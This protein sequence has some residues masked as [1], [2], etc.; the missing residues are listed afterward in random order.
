MVNH[1]NLNTKP[2]REDVLIQLKAL[3]ST[4]TDLADRLEQE[5]VAPLRRGEIPDPSVCNDVAARVAEFFVCKELLTQSS[6]DLLGC[7]TLAAVI[8]K[9]EAT[10]A[11]DGLASVRVA[12]E[13]TLSEV[14]RIA[15][16]P[17][18][19]IPPYVADL[20]T[21]ARD[22]KPV[23]ALLETSTSAKDLL[24]RLKPFQALASL[25]RDLDSTSLDAAEESTQ[26]IESA[27]GRRVAVAL[28][29]GR[30]HL[31]EDIPVDLSPSEII[32]IDPPIEIQ[33]RPEPEQQEAAAPPLALP[34]P[35]PDSIAQSVKDS[36]APR[37]NDSAETTA[38]LRPAHTDLPETPKLQPPHL[39]TEELVDVDPTIGSNE[40]RL[41]AWTLVSDDRCG[42]AYQLALVGHALKE[43]PWS[44]PAPLFKA[45]ALAPYVRPAFTDG[46]F[47][48]ET[49][50][51][52][53][54]PVAITTGKSL[55]HVDA[56]THRLALL[57]ATLRPAL[58][59][60]RCNAAAVVR[61][62]SP[63]DV[64]LKAVGAIRS[65]VQTFSETGLQ[66]D[67]TVL[68]GV[69]EHADWESGL[70]EHIRQL[71]QWLSQERHATLQYAPA[72]EVWRRWIDERG[73]IGSLVLELTRTGATAQATRNRLDTAI[74]EWSN[75]RD[76]GKWMAQKDRELRGQTAGRKPIEGPARLNFMSRVECFVSQ[77]RTWLTHLDSEPGQL[78]RHSQTKADEVRTAIQ[79]A[80]PAARTELRTLASENASDLFLSSAANLFDRALVQIQHLFDQ[81]V[82]ETITPR[83]IA[84]ALHVELLSDPNIPIE[85]DLGLRMPNRSSS[86]YDATLNTLRDRLL[87]IAAVPF[88]ISRA[89]ETA[90]QARRH[91][92]TQL[93]IDSLTSDNRDSD[94]YAKQREDHLALCR[95]QLRSLVT[96][97]KD[98]IE[99]AVCD[100]LLSAD[101]RS[102]LHGIADIDIDRVNDFPAVELDLKEVHESL[103][104]K[105]DDRAVSVARD[106]DL[107][108]SEKGDSLPDASRQII[109]LA[110]NSLEF[111]TAGEYVALARKGEALTP[112]HSSHLET[113][114][115]FTGTATNNWEDG[116]ASRFAKATDSVQPR[117]I[118][119]AVRDGVA[120]GPIQ[121]LTGSAE[122]RAQTAQRL[123]QWLLLKDSR[124]TRE[125]TT[126]SLQS[127]LEGLGFRE[128]AITSFT[129]H[130]TDNRWEAVIT[131]TPL[132][133]RNT[134]VVP[135]F[136]SEANGHYR[137]IGLFDRPNAAGVIRA[138]EHSR[139]D[140]ATLV[141]Y[142]GRMTDRLRRECA[143]E[144]WKHKCKFVVADDATLFFSMTQGGEPLSTLFDC[145]LPFT[146]ST[147]YASTA[148]LVPPEMF[149]GREEER[150]RVIDRTD[151]NLLF[152]GR[153][154]G[155]SAL[156]RDIEKSEHDLAGGRVVKWIDLKNAG[157]GVNR[158]ASEIWAVIGS[159]LEQMTVLPKQ[160]RSHS[161]K[162]VISGIKKWLDG[163]QR[164]TM[165]LLL[166]EADAFL[167]S[168]GKPAEGG[169]A[170]PEVAL[171][172]GL[173][174]D[175][176]RR[177]KVVFAGLHNV[178]RTARDPNTPI[179]HL[180]NP[181][182]VGPLLDN[183]GWRRALDLISEPM[184]R[185]GFMEHSAR[186][187]VWMR[188][189][190][191]T[192]WYPSLIQVFCTHL[193][194]H[195]HNK[196]SYDFASSP[197][198]EVTLEDIEAVYRNPR[199]QDEIRQKFELTLDLDPRYRLIA[200]LISLKCYET[201]DAKHEGVKVDWVRKEALTWWADGFA[202]SDATLSAFRTLLD[203][204]IGL[205]ILRSVDEKRYT[206]R[207]A[208]VLRL[209][210]DEDR[211]T[212][213]LDDISSHPAP[214]QEFNKTFRR[215]L[216]ED[217]WIRSPLTGHQEAMLAKATD[218]VVVVFGCQLSGIDR[219]KN[220]LEA[221]KQTAHVVDVCVAP[222]LS[223]V[224]QFH[225]WLADAIK[226]ANS[227]TTEGVALVVIG[228]DSEWSVEWL[229]YAIHKLSKRS[230]TRRRIRIVFLADAIR[231]WELSRESDFDTL[232][233]AT[234]SL[235]PWHDSFFDPWA[236]HVGLIPRNL[237]S[238]QLQQM[239]GGWP[240]LV[241]TFIEM[242]GRNPVGWQQTLGNVYH[243]W[244]SR[245]GTDIGFPSEAW[246]CLQDI[247]HFERVSKEDL[248]ALEDFFPGVV[249]RVLWWADNLHLTRL[250]ADGLLV[251]PLI[252]RLAKPI[253]T[254]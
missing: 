167:A 178:Q 75:E 139:G 52:D 76:V 22:L 181:I 4:L 58:L 40:V 238:A 25:V 143:R 68:K 201:P 45:M 129:S 166:D 202:N 116:F 21:A 95:A 136:G 110:I 13:H 86:D 12:A 172:K 56:L 82:E 156:L 121:P 163:E 244:L 225:N 251:D 254:T 164:R 84:N 134:C 126:D 200:L 212:Q 235:Q 182:C 17:G 157:I 205:G 196:P 89:F 154:L 48:Y 188:L 192:N 111:Q 206:L 5:A 27:F 231:C 242:T 183:G 44:E 230:S 29:M 98:A 153:Q 174:D 102:E 35:S 147:P 216:N 184:G 85:S 141:F 100:G 140:G 93:L 30:L 215:V 8:A 237:L 241:D 119:D 38:A 213:D 32:V 211:I 252:V 168:D 39:P 250:T 170:F 7:T 152:G 135:H 132:R 88:S 194:E 47:A 222:A 220:G 118:V 16:W 67:T 57:A 180:G 217:P 66:L 214:I 54:D 125:I 123:D 190:S 176:D 233:V 106:Y 99:Q 20:H 101:Q 160:G 115:A 128:V 6:V 81:G 80:L 74:R 41:K 245:H 159:E 97:A 186:A 148:S 33:R 253:T 114:T 14:L 179:G 79:A 122:Q 59:A 83:T 71:L 65:S 120:I 173:M 146:F 234:V 70:S 162:A 92:R 43:M 62:L 219:V 177:F 19:S 73:P 1:A 2:R 149:Y 103:K 151:T 11:S 240:H 60:P 193:L 94:E 117:S 142:F 108:K 223:T 207:S 228:E 131:T 161:S 3:E 158:D 28:M 64:Q 203:E 137:V 36:P 229:T 209:L 90:T 50:I 199:L 210:G 247:A 42:L 198:Y 112:P 232:D 91:D 249:S 18:A 226:A 187:G 31:I 175:K 77:L 227:Y 185:M 195:L 51:N 155:K 24:D 243:T 69:R 165:L 191:Y 236:S 26:L 72:T 15:E 53:L 150:K 171:L 169:Q 208:N 218:G 61:L 9:V 37:E 46:F 87:A 124:D 63:I 224:T 248:P 55:S 239:T 105:S 197:P 127:V 96:D 130:R 23:V 78:D 144:A 104:A 107:L 34:K 246:R 221:M 113:F 189:L 49:A 204:M 109:Q 10:I 145:C 133:S 138:V